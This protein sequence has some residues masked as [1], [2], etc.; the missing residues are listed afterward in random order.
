MNMQQT[1][2]LIELLKILR[3]RQSLYDCTCEELEEKYGKTK[4]SYEEF[5]SLAASSFLDTNFFAS[6]C[7]NNF[8]ELSK[9]FERKRT[10]DN[11]E[12]AKEKE[13]IKAVIKTYSNSTINQKE[14]NEEMQD[15]YLECVGATG[16][17]NNPIEP[18]SDTKKITPSLINR[19]EL[20]AAQQLRDVLE[21]EFTLEK[22][23]EYL[24]W[25]KANLNGNTPEEIK[26]YLLAVASEHPRINA[27]HNAAFLVGFAAI[28]EETEFRKDE[29]LIEELKALI[30]FTTDNEPVSGYVPTF[31]KEEYKEVSKKIKIAIKML[32]KE[33]KRR[34]KDDDKI[35]RINEKIKRREER[36]KKRIQN[37]K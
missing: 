28:M 2:K 16:L 14:K 17:K 35:H 13:W 37:K 4:E 26:N 24:N 32:E 20:Q 10:W 30:K 36:R 23:E 15:T 5:V 11:E 12:I 18:S 34:K 3:I 9:F 8:D 7:S 33:I 6:L 19:L 1:E 21:D 22:Y 27:C 25:N 29:Y 31:D